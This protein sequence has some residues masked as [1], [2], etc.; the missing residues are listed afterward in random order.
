METRTI[1]A[2]DNI[3]LNFD[4]IGSGPPLIL[5]HGGG[6]SRQDWH[7]VG[8]TQKL[9]KDFTVIALDIRGE[10]GDS[11][12]PTDPCAYKIERM[13][14]DV[15]EVA[16]ACNIEKFS[17]WGY[18]Y[19]GNIARF[20]AA[21]SNRIS[22]FVMIG[23]Y[24]GAAAQGNFLN[25]IKEFQ[26]HWPPILE[27][28]KNGTLRLETISDEDREDLEAEDMNVP[29][30]WLTAILD[31]GENSPKDMLCPTLWIFGTDNQNCL[32]SLESYKSEIK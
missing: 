15:L 9:A 13:C 30:A 4:L 31:W 10:I 16:D 24:F 11:G 5:L 12:K 22:S 2:S 18:S 28:Q 29:L 23:V 32:L 25:Y 1:V 21:Q 20:L 3:A 6:Q 14:Q 27:A 26:Q 17:V 19:G 8:Y 7:R